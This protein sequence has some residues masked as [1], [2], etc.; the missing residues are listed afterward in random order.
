MIMWACI[1]TIDFSCVNSCAFCPP[2]ADH[3]FASVTFEFISFISEEFLH[4]NRRTLAI[5]ERLRKARFVH[6]FPEGEVENEQ[7]K[8]GSIQ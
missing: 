1:T 5:H 2:E 6:R 3:H 7:R 8:K 4:H